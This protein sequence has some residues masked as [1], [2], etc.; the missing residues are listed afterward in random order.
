MYN[1]PNWFNVP[2]MKQA[3]SKGDFFIM[4]Y[5]KQKYQLTKKVEHI[6][7]ALLKQQYLNRTKSFPWKF[8]DT[9]TS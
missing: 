2:K 8:F 3:M 9:S 6:K 5:N 1:Y 4:M 7:L